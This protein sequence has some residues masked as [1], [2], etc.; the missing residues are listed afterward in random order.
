MLIFYNY[1]GIM[2]TMI[3]LTVVIMTKTLKT[4]RG[5]VNLPTFMPVGTRGAVKGLTPEQVRSTGAGIVLGN[6]YNLHIA[7]GE[8]IVEKLG[9][10]QKFSGWNG[11]MLTDS[12]GFQVF[13]LAHSRK[14]SEEGV[15]FKDP[16]RGDTIFLSPEISIGIQIK[17]GS[18]II[19]AFDDLTGLDDKA[20][21]RTEEAFERTHRWLERSL[22]EFIRL[23]KNMAENERPLFFGI[24]QG[25]LDIPLRLES[26][27][28]VESLELGGVRVDGIAIGGLSVGE[29]R[30]EMQR[31][32]LA[33][34][35]S[36]QDERPKYLMGVGDP[37]DVRFA[38]AH[39]IDMM[40]CVLPTRN[41][42]HGSVWAKAVCG[43][44]EDVDAV[45]E[46]IH[47]TN[48][49]YFDDPSVIEPGCD[50][51]TCTSG[52]SKG[53]LRHQFKSSES[54]AGTYASVHNLRYLQRICEE[55]RA[56]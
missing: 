8:E 17:L 41:A 31:I 29:P 1:R 15:K 22:G 34:D 56:A 45:D 23:T 16:V 52:V 5:E 50:C 49:K 55:Y 43:V 2:S 51:L 47:L 36:Y 19:M 54:L 21:E 35:E 24:V 10:L 20:K 38:I 40:D 46:R 14:I 25:G 53:F 39:G 48:L 9:G 33:L 18:D 11:P 3:Q 7:P 12:G 4:R 28:K 6:T 13:S 32:L 30:D 44:S 42:R 37:T 27:K 26:L